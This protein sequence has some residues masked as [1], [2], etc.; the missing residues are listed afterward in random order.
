MGRQNFSLTLELPIFCDVKCIN[1]ST[2]LRRVD[3]DFFSNHIFV[4]LINEKENSGTRFFYSIGS[5]NVKLIFGLIRF[6]NRNL[7]YHFRRSCA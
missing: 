3:S 6:F 5:S 7:M 1:C 2:F 4:S